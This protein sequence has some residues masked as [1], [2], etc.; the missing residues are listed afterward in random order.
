MIQNFCIITCDKCLTQH[1]VL[2]S[3]E[4]F[5]ETVG[6]QPRKVWEAVKISNWKDLP[7]DKHLC[8]DCRKGWDVM[9]SKVNDIKREYWGK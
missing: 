6:G 4:D 3:K 8:P 9:A 1:K 2:I 7:D 5:Q